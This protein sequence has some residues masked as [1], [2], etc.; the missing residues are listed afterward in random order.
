MPWVWPKKERKGGRKK[1]VVSRPRSQRDSGEAAVEDEA[2]GS[3]QDV[4]PR[5]RKMEPTKGKLRHAGW[6]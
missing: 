4:S 3:S 2:E 1:N 6:I 5:C